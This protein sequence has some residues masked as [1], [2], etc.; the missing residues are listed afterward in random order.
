MINGFAHLFVQIKENIAKT[1]GVKTNG[2]VD[3][4]EIACVNNRAAQICA[5]DLLLAE[6]RKK[7]GTKFNGLNGKQALH[8]KLLMKYKWPLSLIRELKLEEA[9]LALHDE[10]VFESFGEAA[11]KYLNQVTLS[12]YPVNFPDYLETEWD[13]LLSQKLLFDSADQPD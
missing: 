7:Y 5:L 4:T 13:P 2:F 1:R 9:L 6:H 3:S 8:H 10:L 12:Q 11:S